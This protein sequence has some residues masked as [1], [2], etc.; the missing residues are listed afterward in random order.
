MKP[1]IGYTVYAYFSFYFYIGVLE[2]KTQITLFCWALR[3]SNVLICYIF[4]VEHESA[5]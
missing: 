1:Y 4:N 5:A 2:E 3:C